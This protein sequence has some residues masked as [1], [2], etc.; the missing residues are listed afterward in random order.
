MN[1]NS[2]DTELLIQYLDGELTG[3][4]LEKIIDQLRDNAGLREELE[5]LQLAREAMKSYG[6]KSKIRD[7][8][9]EMMPE[10]KEI[11]TPGTGTVKMIFQTSLRIA[12]VLIVL[13][14]AS[15]LYQ[16]LTVT[17]DKLFAESFSPYQIH[18]L[19]D[20]SNQS[21][22]KS[23]YLKGEADSVILLFHAGNSLQPEDYLMAGITFLEI[24]Q[25]AKAIDI[26]DS[27][28]QKNSIS[29]T[30]LF[31]DD[32]EYYLAE[33]YLQNNEPGKA[34]SIFEKIQADH[35]HAYNSRVSRWFMLK[36]RALRK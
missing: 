7:I 36:L 25:P 3:A 4:Q 14:G 1:E 6:L 8:H 17:P 22:L 16:Y 24:N 12:A 2:T 5:N 31:E 34:A 13:L 29:K 33:S 27:M 20:G 9:K 35:K 26:F 19:R 21:A 15:A 18:N 30:D 10:L 28:I 11:K 23:A 32:A